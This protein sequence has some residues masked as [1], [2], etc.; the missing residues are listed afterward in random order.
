M[1]RGSQTFFPKPLEPIEGPEL[2]FG[3][4]GAIGTDLDQ[5]AD[6]LTEALRRVNYRTHVVRV[7]SLLHQLPK[8]RALERQTF[9]SHFERIKEYMRAGSEV[10]AIVGRGDMLALLSVAKIRELREKFLG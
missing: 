8:Y 2:V 10:R 3:L 4:V 7:S 5:V 9:K 1:A 6:A